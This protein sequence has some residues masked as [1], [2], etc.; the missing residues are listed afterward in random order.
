MFKLLKMFFW[1]LLILVLL[2]GF[3]QFLV[4]VPLD[5]PGLSH[6]Q[7]FYNDFRSRL[8]GLVSPDV[9]V[10]PTSIEQVIETSGAVSL[11]APKATRY[12]YADDSGE[13]QF[14]DSLEQVPVRF[15]KV[16]QPLAE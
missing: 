7:T 13:L 10:L 15:R 14:V 8:I 4:R 12:L 16:A 1:L 5:A 6:A 9:S 3:D 11:P 2:V